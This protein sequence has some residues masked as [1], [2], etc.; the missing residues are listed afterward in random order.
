MFSPHN[1][2]RKDFEDCRFLMAEQNAMDKSKFIESQKANKDLF[3]DDQGRP[4]QN[5]YVWW[6][7]NHAENFRKA[8]FDSLC[9][10]CKNVITCKDCLEEHCLNFIYDPEWHCSFQTHTNISKE[11]S[12][13]TGKICHATASHTTAT[14]CT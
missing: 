7:E 12:R 8:W 1:I 5:F 4:S 6:I 11:V 14:T 10:K 13:K 2:K 3:F 9:R